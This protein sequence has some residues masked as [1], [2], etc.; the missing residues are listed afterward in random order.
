MKQTKQNRRRG[1]VWLLQP[2]STLRSVIRHKEIDM[3]PANFPDR[4]EERRERSPLASAAL[5]LALY[6]SMYSAVAVVVRAFAPLDVSAA[7]AMV[8]ASESFGPAQ[9]CVAPSPATEPATD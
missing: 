4:S 3:D 1:E 2:F 6:I 8:D 5:L 9:P 7:T